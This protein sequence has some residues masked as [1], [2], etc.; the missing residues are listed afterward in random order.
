MKTILYST[1]FVA[2]CILAAITASASPLPTEMGTGVISHRA[3]SSSSEISSIHVLDSKSKISAG[4]QK[5]DSDTE[6]SNGQSE[7]KIDL[8][9]F[10]KR[11]K[12]LQLEEAALDHKIGGQKRKGLSAGTGELRRQVRNVR[13]NK[14][15]VGVQRASAIVKN[16]AGRD[17]KE[18]LESLVKKLQYLKRS[19]T[20]LLQ[21]SKFDDPGT[22]GGGRV[23]KMDVL[24]NASPELKAQWQEA[25][26]DVDAKIAKLKQ[27]LED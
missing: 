13:L 25:V 24:K 4:F 11:I 10:E 3:P 26:E 21:Q 16:V 19:V 15:L 17:D 12:Q 2:A 8:S 7:D 6:E 9:S 23:F 1:T 27:L 22:D 20:Y 5:K 14:G 18:A